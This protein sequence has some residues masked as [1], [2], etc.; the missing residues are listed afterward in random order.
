V[1]RPLHRHAIRFAEDTGAATIEFAITSTILFMSIFGVIGF[2]LA[3]FAH[4]QVSEAAREGTRYAMVHGNTCSNNGSSCAAT[5]AEIQTYVQGLALTGITASSL[6][7]TTSYS[8]YPSGATCTPN[9]NCTNPGNLVTV[10]V[11]YPAPLNV[12]FVPATVLSMSGSSSMVIS[13]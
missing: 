10:T 1:Q 3:V 2:S 8:A 6:S 11:S 12:P 4:H 13:Q 9:A 7:V 5:A